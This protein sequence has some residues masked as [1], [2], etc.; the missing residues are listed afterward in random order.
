M[1]PLLQR[2]LIENWSVL[3]LGAP[4]PRRLDFL[5]Q[6]TGIGKLCCY[7]FP[8]GAAEPR[9]V[10]KMRRSPVENDLLRREYVLI[11]YL[12]ESGSDY[13]R[14][15]IPGPLVETCVAGHQLAIE[16]YLPGRA[17]DGLLANAGERTRELAAAYRDLALKWLLRCQRETP[18][19]RSPLRDQ[20]IDDYFL[21]PIARLRSSAALT[22]HESSYLDQ[23][24]RQV[25][26]LR[27]L[28]LPLVFKHGDFQPGNILLRDNAPTVIDW[29]FGLPTALPLLDVFGFLLRNHTRQQGREEMDGYLEDYLLDFD[30]VFFGSGPITRQSA[31]QVARAVQA[32]DFDPDWVPVLFAMFIVNEANKYDTLLRRRSERGYLYLLRSRNQPLPRSYLDQLARQKNVWLLGHLV[33]QERRLAVADASPGGRQPARSATSAAGT[34][35][36]NG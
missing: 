24:T 16:P 12:R 2:Y 7:I 6:A 15:T 31:D 5:V 35:W 3:R 20:Q 27:R 18:R 19:V 34:G 30:T 29:E 13:V 8:N 26:G 10:A 33:S 32:L 23:V 9:W 21:G 14:R 17:M 28:P 11:N 25:E 4:P 36:G 22:D 1:L